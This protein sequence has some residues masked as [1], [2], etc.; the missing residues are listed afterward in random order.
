LGARP[1]PVL[2]GTGKRVFGSGT[3]PTALRLVDS[4]TFQSGTVLLTYERAGKPTYGD[5]ALDAG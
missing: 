1:Y 4:V 3:V 5:M 2:L